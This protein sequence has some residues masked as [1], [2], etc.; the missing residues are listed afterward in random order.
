M[1]FITLAIA[2]LLLSSGAST[3]VFAADGAAPRSSA[4]TQ[5]VQDIPNI[6]G[7]KFLQLVL[8]YP[9]GVKSPPHRHAKSAFIYAYVLSGQV[10]SQVDDGP[11]KVYGPGEYWHENPG[12]HHRVSENASAT[13]PAKVLVIMVLDS[14][15]T[16]LTTPD[17]Q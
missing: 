6:P 17:P 15:E 3:A 4:T 10:R 12:A 11:A 7:K 2:G 14:T 9:P 16:T 8:E 13:A 1:K 5:F